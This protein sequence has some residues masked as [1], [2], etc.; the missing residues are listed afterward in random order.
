LEFVAFTESTARILERRLLKRERQKIHREIFFRRRRCRTSACS[1]RSNL[2]DFST[3]T[4]GEDSS[5]TPDLELTYC[6]GLGVSA[7]STGQYSWL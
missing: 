5:Q 6:W 7:R 4:Y 3:W 2:Q 1:L